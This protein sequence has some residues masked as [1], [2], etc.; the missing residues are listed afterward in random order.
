MIPNSHFGIVF[1]RLSPA[2]LIADTLSFG[3]SRNG[4]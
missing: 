2:C 4:T 1:L 3:I